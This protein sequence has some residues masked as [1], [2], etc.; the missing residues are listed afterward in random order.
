M[1]V[2]ENMFD[3]M[4]PDDDGFNMTIEEAEKL[5]KNM[6]MLQ[7]IRKN[8]LMHNAKIFNKHLVE[9]EVT[10]K[11]LDNFPTGWKCGLND[12]NLLTAV[13]NFGFNYLSKLVNEKEFTFTDFPVTSRDLFNRLA[14][15]CEFYREISGGN[16]IK[17]KKSSLSLDLGGQGN[18][19][20][21][22]NQQRKKLSSKV[23]I[24]INI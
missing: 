8:I 7:F 15:L 1:S 13:K 20:G 16:K 21:N 3:Q 2:D 18:G 19:S 5:N 23:I 17:K 14:F 22:I 24:F 6:N 4:D 12:L 11:K 9:L 10:T